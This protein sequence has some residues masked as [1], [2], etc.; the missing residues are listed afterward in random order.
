MFYPVSLDDV[1]HID[2]AGITVST[3]WCAHRSKIDRLLA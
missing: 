2:S 1:H 3:V